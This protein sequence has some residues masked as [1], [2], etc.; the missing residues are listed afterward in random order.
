MKAVAIAIGALAAIQI[1]SAISAWHFNVCVE[2]WKAN[3]I[4]W[5]NPMETGRAVTKCNGG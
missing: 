4:G 5:G 3:K 1:P 2:Q